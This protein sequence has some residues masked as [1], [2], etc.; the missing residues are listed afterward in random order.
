MVHPDATQIWLRQICLHTRGS[1]ALAL[2][3]GS[4]KA[5][6]AKAQDCFGKENQVLK[7]AVAVAPQEWCFESGLVHPQ[8]NYNNYT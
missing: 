5:P 7:A 4:A 1:P 8:S 2:A 6:W 3:F